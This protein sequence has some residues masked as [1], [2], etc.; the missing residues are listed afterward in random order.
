MVFFVMAN[1]DPMTTREGT[2][3]PRLTENWRGQKITTPHHFCWLSRTMADWKAQL[4]ANGIDDPS[5]WTERL[6]NSSAGTLLERLDSELRCQICQ[7][8]Y[9]APVSLPCHHTFCSECIRKAFAKQFS[10]INRST[11]CVSCNVYVD[12]RNDKGLVPNRTLEHAVQAFAKLRSPLLQVLEDK[13]PSETIADEPKTAR[14]RSARMKSSQQEDSEEEEDENNDCLSQ[15]SR[16][17]TKRSSSPRGKK[18]KPFYGKKKRAELKEMCRKEGL[19]DHG[20]EEDLRARHQAF[21][22]LYNSESDSLNPMNSQEIVNE[23]VKREKERNR[24]HAPTLKDVKASKTL[25]NQMNQNFSQLIANAKHRRLKTPKDGAVGESAENAASDTAPSDHN[26]HGSE[27]TPV[28][29][30]S[31]LSKGPSSLSKA[32]EESLLEEQAPSPKR[33]RSA[34][35]T[36]APANTETSFS[37]SPSTISS[38]PSTTNESKPSIRT[39]ARLVGP[40]VS[41]SKQRPSLKRKCSS[42]PSIIGPW[43]CRACTF[44]NTNRIGSMAKCEVCQTARIVDLT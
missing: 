25:T 23:I 34:R 18:S 21:I 37:S 4:D 12:N 13:G 5:I 1:C 26:N 11:R 7:E 17:R 19:P 35:T 10:S 42:P 33:K 9:R 41:S 16:Q 40:R 39:V 27:E 20:S 15:E 2:L 38:S 3:I 36:I 32:T 30:K 14:R 31:P 8:L 44:Y 22:T 29:R 24:L 28:K 6:P 43:S